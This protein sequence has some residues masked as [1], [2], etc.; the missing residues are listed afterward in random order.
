[1]L[2][3]RRLF[4]RHPL[5]P[6]RLLPGRPPSQDV[7]KSLRHD[8]VVQFYT[9]AVDAFFIYVALE[10]FVCPLEEGR[11]A[12]PRTLRRLVKDHRHAARGGRVS[13]LLDRASKLDVLRQITS[14]VAYLHSLG[15]LHRDIK[16]LNV[17]V[18]SGEDGEGGGRFVAKVSDLEFVKGVD[19]SSSGGRG[20]RA[21]TLAGGTTDWQA[22]EVF[23]EEANTKGSDMF[24]LGLVSVGLSQCLAPLFPQLSAT[25]ASFATPPIASPPSRPSPHPPSL[26]LAWPP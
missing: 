13:P 11:K 6:K 12:E 19:D 20:G 24:S 10:P 22:P 18:R 8:H 4:P 26:G 14:A 9:H 25:P 17:L 2:P 23:M 1:M 16:P 5:H 7:L 21:S 15:Q 3:K